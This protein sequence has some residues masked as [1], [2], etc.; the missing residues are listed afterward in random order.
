VAGEGDING[1]A[2]VGQ[3][4]CPDGGAVG[5]GDGADD[6][7]AQAV[8]AVAAGGARA[9]PLEGLEQAVELGCGD[10]LPGVGHRQD[11]VTAAG[12]RGDLDVPAG[13]VVLDGVVDQV[14]GQLL[15]QERVPVENGRLDAGV[16]LQAETADRGAG[17]GQG[18]AG[19]GGQVGGLAV[20][21]AGFAAGQGEQRLDQAFL[22]GV[23][24]EQFLAYGLPGFGGA[25]RVGE[26][27]LE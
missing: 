6:G 19:D 9:E 27:D 22:F 5:G 21:G 8:A 24:G 3:G 15:D 11:G 18:G 20:A 13:D 17:G 25:G 14:G 23:G 4:P 26:S 12:R 10:D 1:K 16:D 7:Q 2:A